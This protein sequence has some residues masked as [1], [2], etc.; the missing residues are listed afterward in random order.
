V[1]TPENAYINRCSGYL[2]SLCKTCSAVSAKEWRAQNGDRIRE[3]TAAYYKKN[4]AKIRE[5]R[6]RAR[7]RRE[8]GLTMEQLE[9]K[10]EEQG[11]LCA[12]CR[13]AEPTCI[14]HCHTTGKVRDLLCSQCNTAIGMLKDDP[15][16]LRAAADYIEKHRDVPVDGG[17][18]QEFVPANERR[19][20]FGERG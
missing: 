6:R 1:C 13:I 20:P 8:Y 3:T 11:R 5:R 16:F 18:V 7:F 4:R 15:C 2:Q 17:D 12:I 14:D 9:A 10:R 19:V